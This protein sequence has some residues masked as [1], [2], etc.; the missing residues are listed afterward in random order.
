MSQTR[1]NELYQYLTVECLPF[2][3]LQ[4]I[5]TIGESQWKQQ[6]PIVVESGVSWGICI[7]L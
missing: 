3:A 7:D 2:T 1:T 6:G 4:L 5:R